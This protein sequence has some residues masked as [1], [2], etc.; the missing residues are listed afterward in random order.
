M[1]RRRI[2]IPRYILDD[3]R[4]FLQEF[5]NEKHDFINGIKEGRSYKWYFNG[6]GDLTWLLPLHHYNWRNNIIECLNNY[7][8]ERKPSYI[9]SI[10]CHYRINNS[11]R[12]NID[13]RSSFRVHIKFE[14]F[15]E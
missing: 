1:F 11:S 6:W 13:A 12:S 9:K 14:S 3:T 10:K 2:K 5:F 7:L 8:M 4:E 15:E